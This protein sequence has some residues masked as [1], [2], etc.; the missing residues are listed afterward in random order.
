MIGEQN[1][2]G[3]AAPESGSTATTMA[4]DSMRTF[5]ARLIPVALSIVTGIITAKWLG[6]AGKGIYS[7]TLMLVSIIMV[8][9][10]GVAGAITYALTKQRRPLSELLPAVAVLFLSLSVLSGLGVIAWGLLRGW[11][12]VLWIIIAAV[13]PSVIL[14]WQSALY[15]GLG[16]LRN[17]NIQSI[18]LALA[19]LLGVASAIAVFRGGAIGALLAWLL[20]LY[21]AALVVVLH[22]MRLGRGPHRAP[23]GPMLA[24]LVRFGGPSTINTFLGTLNYRIDSIILI[25]IM[26]VA[27]FGI[28]SIAVSFGELLFMLSRPVTAAATREIGIRSPTGS[29]VIT[30]KIIRICTAFVA[31]VS[32]IAFVFGPWAIDVVYGTRFTSAA[33]PLRIL[34]PGIVA[35][36]TAGTFAAFFLFQVGRPLIVAAINVAMI[37]VQATACFILVPRFGLN[38]AAFASS[39]T[40]VAG[41]V[42]N[43]AWFCRLTGRPF[44]EVWILRRSDIHTV[45][46]A[47]IDRSGFAKRR[48]RTRAA[49]GA[50]GGDIL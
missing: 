48:S 26:G 41:A 32:I 5:V 28:Y 43:T 37:L 31:A 2:P 38:G 1:V 24:G 30:A 40:Y 35:F 45:R 3:A 17:L 4:Y 47:V 29:A 22:V 42:M 13:P 11:G 44:W 19:T 25:A 20:C 18:G 46:E 10:A 7:G 49:A 23:L 8:A 6:P 34:L 16:R 12:P 50:V 9:P 21:G 36:S 33:T 15:I 27:Q 14:V 39:A